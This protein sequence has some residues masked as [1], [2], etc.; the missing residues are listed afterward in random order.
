M[1]PLPLAG[2]DSDVVARV[3][4]YLE[5]LL[6]NLTQCT[7]LLERF[8]KSIQN[9]IGAVLLSSV[10]A[11]GEPQGRVQ[12][13]LVPEDSIP[14]GVD[15]EAPAR[16]EGEPGII[17]GWSVRYDK[18]VVSIGNFRASRSKKPTGAELSSPAI[19]VVDF[20]KAPAGGFV[21]AELE[22]VS[23]ER[24]D[25]VGY[26]MPKATSSAQKAPFTAQA[27]Y[28]TMVSDGLSLLLQGRVFE[29]EAACA[30]ATRD[31]ARCKFFTWKIAAPTSFADCA[32]EEGDAGFA[33]PTGGTQVVKPTVHGDHWFFTNITQGAETTERRAQWMVTGDTNGDGVTTLDELKGVPASNAFPQSLGYNLSGGF[34]GPINTAYDY[35]IEQ[36]STLGDYNGDGECPTRG[37]L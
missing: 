26:D 10:F 8:V 27:D 1:T 12:V 28:D 31:L 13:V 30:D 22:N 19:H 18:F 2:E 5:D 33:V 29:D 15:A 9:M 11:C 7:A 3:R 23:A 35:L 36:A 37:K 16:G 4:A 34:R 25:R 32:N 17:D 20:T 14:D 24:W 6:F 21:I